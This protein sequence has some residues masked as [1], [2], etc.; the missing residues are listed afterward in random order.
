[1]HFS[2]LLFPDLFYMTKICVNIQN[3]K[4]TLKLEPG[5]FLK[6]NEGKYILHEELRMQF[7]M[8]ATIPLI[9]G[10]LASFLPDYP[11]PE[12]RPGPDINS[13][14]RWQGWIIVITGRL[15]FRYG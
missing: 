3:K 9:A 10:V 1:M 7:E 4:P 13:V 14:I 2:S 8:I 5:I 12:T 6:L 15:N 11:D